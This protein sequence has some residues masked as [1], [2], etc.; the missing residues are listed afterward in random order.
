MVSEAKSKRREKKAG[1]MFDS[2]TTHKTQQT[3]QTSTKHTTNT[4]E[5]A[6]RDAA[7]QQELDE[8]ISIIDDFSQV[9]E[10]AEEQSVLAKCA[11]D[12]KTI[13]EAME[14]QQL[15]MRQAVEQL[16]TKI[17]E[18]KKRLR[19]TE[20]KEEF[21][22]RLQNV[23]QERERTLRNISNTESEIKC[24]FFPFVLFAKT[25]DLARRREAGKRLTNGISGM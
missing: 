25:I 20:T 15:N 5:T 17:Q 12:R 14:L 22:S 10:R 1:K 9:I 2:N 18:K 19:R 11:N 21:Q 13:A 3:Q 24:V 7:R 16:D 4:M 8:I 23:V 6:R